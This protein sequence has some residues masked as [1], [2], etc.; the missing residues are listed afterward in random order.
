MLPLESDVPVPDPGSLVS[1]VYLG[2]SLMCSVSHFARVD[3]CEKKR[4]MLERGGLT[5]KL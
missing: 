5:V 2:K 1:C 4:T 3:N